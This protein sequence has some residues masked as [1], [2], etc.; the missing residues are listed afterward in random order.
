MQKR[1]LSDLYDTKPLESRCQKD[2]FGTCK[3]SEIGL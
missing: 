3:S 2:H 1:I